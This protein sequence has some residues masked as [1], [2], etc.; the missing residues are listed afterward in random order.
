MYPLSFLYKWFIALC[1]VFSF[2][3]NAE[4]LYSQELTNLSL[5]RVLN[6]N[7][8]VFLPQSISQN[9]DVEWYGK[10]I[11]IDG[12]NLVHGKGRLVF[13]RKDDGYR[14]VPYNVRA[15]EGYIVN[16]LVLKPNQ[17][18][19]CLDE[20]CVLKSLKIV[21][22][23][24]Q[25][26]KTIEE[27]A[28]FNGEV[29]IYED[30]LVPKLGKLESRNF[31]Y[32][33]EFNKGE[34]T[35]FGKF[36]FKSKGVFSCDNALIVQEGFWEKGRFLEGYLKT[37]YSDGAVYEGWSINGIPDGWGRVL[38]SDGSRYVGEFLEGK[39]HGRGFYFFSDGSWYRGE[40]KNDLKDGEGELYIKP[41][42]VH[43][44]GQ[45]KAGKIHGWG[46][47]YIG[48]EFVYIGSFENN[49]PHGSGYLI[50][51]SGNTYEVIVNNGNI[52]FVNSTSQKLSLYQLFSS[53][54]WAFGIPSLSDAVNFFS[55]KVQEVADW[56]EKN[57]THII[58]ATKGCIAGGIG[59]A[60]SGAA[61]GAVAGAVVGNVVAGAA[62][63]AA[64][65]V[66][67]G[68]LDQA[69]K[70]FE[71]SLSGE[72]YTLED[73]FQSFEDEAFSAENFVI[74]AVGGAGRA[75]KTLN[76]ASKAGK[77]LKKGSKILQV[78]EK[79]AEVRIIE[80][81]GK[82]L[83]HPSVRQAISKLSQQEERAVKK[84]YSF[85]CK[86]KFI[87]R[88]CREG[89]PF[90]KNL[91]LFSWNL[92][93]FSPKGRKEKD[94]RLIYDFLENRNEDI[95]LLQEV[96][97]ARDE[98]WNGFWKKLARKTKRELKV[99]KPRDRGETFV[100]L[101]KKSKFSSVQLIDKEVLSTLP[102]ISLG[103]KPAVVCLQ[104]KSLASKRKKKKLKERNNYQGHC[105]IA[106]INVHVDFT[107]KMF[108]KKI[109]PIK[110]FGK[111]ILKK[112]ES[113]NKIRL[114]KTFFSLLSI[115]QNLKR[116]FSPKV[117]II[118]GDFNLDPDILNIPIMKLY[119][120]VIQDITTIGGKRYDNFLVPYWVGSSGE[121]IY[122]LVCQCPT[123]K[124][125]SFG[126]VCKEINS[127][128]EVEQMGTFRE[129]YKKHI[130]DHFPITAKLQWIF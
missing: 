50:D 89:E 46:E 48:N 29:G 116:K 17:F 74:G 119:R 73:A 126:Q 55:K 68:C 24:V 38:W 1:L 84:V 70:A 129:C 18:Y 13:I 83:M 3:L 90:P 95:I 61:G 25:E 94:K 77:I 65:G 19:R 67:S 51:K 96:I 101:A 98:S 33:G 62:V 39:K 114:T 85:L 92:G 4:V 57:K 122:S 121:V 47:L 14:S 99:S 107:M 59:G 45:F 66:L 81:A 16:D 23:Y 130:S 110:V 5:V 86:R 7:I 22:S 27:V 88:F 44:V 112:E 97:K 34:I 40:Y 2:F 15:E 30:V 79:I 31:I 11:T 102:L 21:F 105:D 26:E 8:F 78:G 37:A 56:V 125:H 41:L 32:E 52:L 54:A 49:L 104:I 113:E 82:P 93:N 6:D 106:V 71:K 76:S 115:L 43:Y 87:K 80:K 120:P 103:R 36:C 111:K 117:I 124:V 128:Q 12:R 58:N 108:G 118:G 42:A 100:F 72:D 10:F 28:T 109:K 63:G 53:E 60:I 75:L 127:Y 91:T 35:G 69:T 20:N 123:D 9:F 64:W